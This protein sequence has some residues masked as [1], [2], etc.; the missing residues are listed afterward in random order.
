MQ[1]RGWQLDQSGVFIRNFNLIHSLQDNS[2]DFKWIQVTSEEF[3]WLQRNSSNSIYF[4]ILQC[5]LTI[6]KDFRKFSENSLTSGDFTKL[7]D[8]IIFTNYLFVPIFCTNSCGR[9]EWSPYSFLICQSSLNLEYLSRKAGRFH[10]LN[11]KQFS[12]VKP[13]IKI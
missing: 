8:F 5:L 10:S 1:A 2:R 13:Q 4:K 12:D 6:S 9:V 7:R 11:F 3:K